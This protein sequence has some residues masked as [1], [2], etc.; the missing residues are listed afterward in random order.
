L[1]ELL[2]PYDEIKF[3]ILTG[4][5]ACG[6]M[7][8]AKHVANPI[9]K[10]MYFYKGRK[11]LEAVIAGNEKVAELRFL[12]YSI[13]TNAPSFLGY[14]SHIAEDKLFLKNSVPFLDDPIL[15]NKIS[16]YLRKYD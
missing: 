15:S 1:I 12:R 11:M 5:R 2:E 3:P 9:S 16:A 4:Y 6:T 13:Q 8:M 14:N 7:I 10:L